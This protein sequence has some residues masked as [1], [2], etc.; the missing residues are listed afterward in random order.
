MKRFIFAGGLSMALVGAA[1][2][3]PLTGWTNSGTLTDNNIV[4]DATNVVNLGVLDIELSGFGQFG[5]SDVLTYT[6]RG[7][8]YCDDGFEFNDSPA[9]F[10]NIG[11]SANFINQNPGQVYGGA[12]VL[13]TGQVAGITP[14]VPPVIDISATNITS[15]GVLQVGQTG[16][17]S[18]TGSAVNLGHG[19]VIV[20]GFDQAASGLITGGAILGPGQIIDFWGG[21]LQSN[22]FFFQN[23]ALADVSTG[24]SKTTNSAHNPATFNLQIINGFA[25]AMTNNLNPSNIYTQAIIYVDDLG[26]VNESAYFLPPVATPIS[27]N[28]FGTAV[29][30]W[31]VLVTNAF[32]QVFSNTL[33]MSDDL[34]TLP[35]NLTFVTN[36]TTLGG[37]TQ[38]VPT[39]YAFASTFDDRSLT[40]TGNV[41]YSQSLFTNGFGTNGT[42][43][44]T[45]SNEYAT[46]GLTLSPVTIQPDTTVAGSTYSNVPARVQITANQSLDLTGSIIEAGNYLN[47]TSPNDYRGSQGAQISF[48]VA[49]F[50]LGTSNG[51]MTISNL[52]VPY[53][54]RF[55]GDIEAWSTVWTNLTMATN[56]VITAT[57]TNTNAFSVTNGFMVTI[58]G[59]SINPFSIPSIQNL[60]LRSTNVVISDAL[61]VS[62]NLLINAQNLT[63]T[64]NGPTDLT[65]TGA[66]TFST[67]L[68]DDL[69]S[70][71]LPGLL[72]FTNA[73]TFT[74]LNAAFFQT[75]LNP[76][77]PSA[78]DGP[79]QSIVNSGEIISEAGGDIF[80]ANSFQ[81][82]GFVVAGTGPIFVTSTT[83]LITNGQMNASSGDM[84]FTSGSLTIAN[85]GLGASGYLNLAASVLLTDLTPSG[86]STITNGNFFSAGDGFSLLT[87]PTSPSGLLGTSVTSACRSNAVCQNSWAGVPVAFPTNVAATPLP[88]MAGNAP[89][90]QLVLDGGNNNSV[91]HFQGANFDTVNPYA[92]YVDQIELMDGATNTNSAGRYT[93]FNIDT[94]VTI[95]FLKASV[96]TNSVSSALAGQAA[97]GGHLVWLQNNVGHFSAT[98]VTYSD[99][100][101]FAVNSAY[102]QA[103]GLPPEPP[104][105]LTPQT[106]HLQIGTTNVNSTP[107][108]AI[109]WY[110]PA[111]STNTLYTRTF[112][113]TNWL[114][115]TNFV[116][117]ASSGRVSFL[118][119]MA[120]N[121]LYKVGV[122]ASQ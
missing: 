60:S 121:H 51:Q 5:F 94:N 92:I 96:G 27:T 89:I 46:L 84:S 52:V 68:G 50:N 12:V 14:L 88:T 33:Y 109:S 91:F 34:G 35:T 113:N 80:W 44:G 97:G 47:L 102:V 42:G 26:L 40:N 21:G 24:T 118:D 71:N 10:G 17:I 64:S 8:M 120:T 38:L 31:S 99:G 4:I 18:V 69:Y 67:P 116:Q 48:P 77:N 95:Y 2:A 13:Q 107:K 73:G 15:S 11:P 108:A 65:P 85:E 22:N 104:V 19:S 43:S 100:Q 41:P 111:Y 3:G 70:A 53:L 61:T 93:A 66:L 119:S 122:S 16:L 36:N 23:L 83:A 115:R 79:W 56:I 78:G 20:E 72:N 82:S 57:A 101:T 114:V 59:S 55:S 110:A 63:I 103:Y 9:S 25:I 76:N 74:T 112:L 106:I 32:G 98:K 117:G 1:M 62:N 29:I 86:T 58:V 90:G 28:N 30:K 105:P 7:I 54:T 75:R 49:D 45:I 37:L 81:N 6:N 39:N 87:A